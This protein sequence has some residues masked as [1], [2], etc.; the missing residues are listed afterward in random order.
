MKSYRA[1]MATE[2]GLDTGVGKQ[3]MTWTRAVSRGEKRSPSAH[4]CPGTF[5]IKASEV[6]C[7]PGTV[8]ARAPEEEKKD[9]HLR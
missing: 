3:V 5:T 4:V 6:G 2:P 7:G 1:L 8:A 9:S